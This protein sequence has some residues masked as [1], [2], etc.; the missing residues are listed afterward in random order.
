[1]VMRRI[2]L[3]LLFLL[4]LPA[5]SFGAPAIDFGSLSHDFGVVSGGEMVRY[6]F[7]FLNRGDKDLIIER[8][9]A[10]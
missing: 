1:M 2:V 8:L 6:D 5:L 7:D 4:F 3:P 10:S 9:S